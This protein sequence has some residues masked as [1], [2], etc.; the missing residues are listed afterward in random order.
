MFEKIAKW[1]VSHNVTTHTIAAIFAMAVL[2]YAQV[3][4]FHDLV[5]SV[6]S[7]IPSWCQ[8]VIVTA[9]ALYSWYRLRTQLSNPSIDGQAAKK[10]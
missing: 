1:F 5:L 10:L 7:H 4:S 9:L 2:A 6:Y 8:Q 3:Q